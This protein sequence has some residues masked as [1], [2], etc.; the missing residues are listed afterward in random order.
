MRRSLRILLAAL[1]LSATQ[2][3]G[4]E[5]PR[6]EGFTL[7]MRF[8]GL[9]PQVITNLNLNVV[10]QGMDER[11]MELVAPLRFD[12]DGNL[13]DD[14]PIAYDVADDGALEID[15]AG[16]LVR[17]RV[18]DNGDGTFTYEVQV[19]SAIL[20]CSEEGAEC[21]FAQEARARTPTPQLTVIADRGAEAI[22]DER[23][24]LPAWPLPVGGGADIT[25]PC[26]A[27]AV[28]LCRN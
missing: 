23:L 2:C 14:G 19:W 15:V 16:E 11:F 10:P 20:S 9:D 24:F 7:S 6:P 1:A 4:E 3:G 22:A 25:V 5:L 17:D 8:T 28:D 12:A 13:S 18:Q 21:E 26:R 27:S